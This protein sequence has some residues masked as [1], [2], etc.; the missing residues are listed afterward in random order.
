MCHRDTPSWQKPITTFFGMD[1]N[2]HKRKRDQC[3]DDIAASSSSS[4][5]ETVGVLKENDINIEA[6]HDATE[7]EET[8]DVKNNVRDENGTEKENNDNY[9]KNGNILEPEICITEE[10]RT[11]NYEGLCK[12][13]DLQEEKQKQENKM[14]C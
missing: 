8:A 12:W 4:T 13:L 11:I 10:K 3:D 14:K 9:C 2:M 7:K 5:G 1:P 6:E